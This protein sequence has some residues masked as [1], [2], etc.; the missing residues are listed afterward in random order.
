[1]EERKTIDIQ[2]RTFKFGVKIIKFVD[3]LPHTLSTTEL[4]SNF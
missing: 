2:E 4:G 1:M 3:K